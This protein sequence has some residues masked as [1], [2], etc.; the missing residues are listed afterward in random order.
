MA[1]NLQAILRL[2]GS[3]FSNALRSITRQTQQANNATGNFVDAQGR[4]RNSLG[5]FT[6]SSNLASR[7]MSTLSRSITSPM[8]SIGSLTSSLGGLAAAYA[9]VNGAQKIFEQ[10]VGEAA[11]Y[12]Q[13]T[14]T[15]AA[16]LNDKELGKQ[17]MDLVDSYAIDSPIMDSQSMLGNS[18]SFLTA[19]KDMG[20]LEK[21]WSLAER[22]AAIDPYQGVEGAVFALRELF[23][24]DAISIV[25]RF[26][27]PKKVMNEIKKMELDD[28][29]RELDKYF[30]SIGMTQHLIDEMGGTTLG[31]WAQ[32][33]E[34]ANVILRT[35]G[36]PA[37]NVMKNF[38]NG[39]KSNMATV[40]EVMDA[41]NFFTPEEF[42]EKLNRAMMFESFQET[43]AKILE[44]IMV[45]L[46]SAMVGLGKWFE[47]IKSNPEFQAQTT[48]FGQVKFVIEDIYQRFL[49]WLDEGGRDKIIK[50]TADLMQIVIAGVEAS[51]ENILPIA[52]KVGT[53]IG[54]GILSGVKQSLSES[55][56]A[57]LM[58]DPVGFIINEPINA[59]TGKNDSN[60]L[61][62]KDHL[63]NRKN[64]YTPKK[65]GGLNYVPYD[66]ANYSL[67]KGEMI[68]PRGEAA[69]YRRKRGGAGGGINIS[70]NTFHVRE[71]GDIQK[72]AMQLALLIE[73]EGAQMGHG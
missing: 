8:R 25:R 21:M 16:M 42:R 44:N 19:S 66:G 56:F 36:T 5:Q 65:N 3:Q 28:Q 69:E 30:N 62:Y 39:L 46:T 68:L 52:I 6:R 43:G 1:F 9:A 53:A 40:D 57:K 47:S 71:E 50:T 29:L 20:Q 23:S 37:L 27:M 34:S 7:S 4:L 60:I 38:L 59:I 12:E 15:I 54:G 13:S 61:G 35:M 11:K 18:K 17:Y 67:H 64:G 58:A 10:T 55:W 33:K 72:I 2:N 48:L 14:I 41:K 45:G 51:I 63:N 70:G 22:M 32:I 31:V 24:G 26:E 49:T 73:S